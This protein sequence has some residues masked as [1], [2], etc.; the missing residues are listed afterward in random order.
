M[1]WLREL[2]ASRNLL[3]DLLHYR[4]GAQLPRCSMPAAQPIR[5][6]TKAVVRNAPANGKQPERPRRNRESG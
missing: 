6:R 1:V 2:G 5:E 3:L 4:A